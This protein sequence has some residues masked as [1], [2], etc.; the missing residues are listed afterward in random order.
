MTTME[1]LFVEIFDR[2]DR[3]IEQMQQQA[4][5][6]TQQLASRLVIDGIKP[7]SWLLSP[8]SNSHSSYLTELE[9]EKI[10][11]RLL[12]QP[13][14]ESTR[15]STGGRFYTAPDMSL[16]CQNNDIRSSLNH[17]AELDDSVEFPQNETNARTTS[18][19]NATDMSLECQNNDI[20]CSLNC[21]AEIDSVESPQSETNSRITSIYTAPVISLECQNNYTVCSLNRVAELDDRVESPQNAMNAKITSIYTAPDTSLAIIQRSRSRQKAREL[22]TNVKTTGKSRLSNENGDSN[23]KKDLLQATQ[24]KHP[25]EVDKCDDITGST[26]MILEEKGHKAND[27]T[28]H[29]VTLAKLSSSYEK[30][31]LENDLTKKGSSFDK[32]KLDGGIII[33]PTGDSLQQNGH[34]DNLPNFCLGSY[35]SKKSRTGKTHGTQSQ[36]KPYCGRITRS[37]SSSQQISRINKSVNMGTSVSCNLKEGGGALSHSVGDLMHKLTFSGKLLDAVETSQVLS[38][39]NGKTQTICSTG[40]VLNPDISSNMDMKNSSLNGNHQENAGIVVGNR[41]I[42]APV[43][44]QPVS[45]GKLD[46]SSSDCCMKVKPKQL[47][48]DEISQCDLNDIGSPLSKKRKPDGMLG[49]KCYPSNE[50]ASSIDRNSISN[51]FEQQLPKANV[52]SSSPN[53]AKIESS[54]NTNACTKDEMINIGLETNESPVVEDVKHISMVSLQGDIDVTCEVNVSSKE[55]GNTFNEETH[56]GNSHLKGDH[57]HKGE[58]SAAGVLMPVSPN[59]KASFISS[60]TKQ[61][62]GDFEVDLG[63]SKSNNIEIGTNLKLSRIKLNSAKCNTCPLNQQNTLEYQPNCF[64]DSRKFRV[65]IQRDA[66]HLNLKTPETDLNTVMESASILSSEKI[67][68]FQS[69]GIQSCDKSFHNEIVCDSPEGTE[70]LHELQAAEATVTEVDDG[71][72]TL[73]NTLKQSEPTTVLNM[74]KNSADVGPVSPII[75]DDAVVT[76]NNNFEINFPEWV[77]SYDSVQLSQN[78][79]KIMVSDEVTP[80]YESFL[81]DEEIGNINTENNDYGIDFDTLEIAST[82]YARASIIEQICKSTSMQTPLSQFKILDHMDIG[83]SVSLDEDSLKHLQTS[84]SCITENDYVFPQHHKVSYATPFSWQSKNYYSSPTGKLWERSASSSGSSEKQ[85]SSNP[86]LTCFP[87]EEDPSSNEENDE[88]EENIK[89]ENENSVKDYEMADEIQERPHEST[90]VWSQHA[91]HVSTKSIKYPDRYSSNSVSIEASVP[92]TREKVK[93][94]PKVHHGFKA[95]MHDKEN[96][97]SSIETRAS[98]RGNLSEMSRNKN[99]MRSGIPRQLQFA[100]KEA[101][102]NNIVSNITSFVPI[103]QQK[104]AAADCTGKRDIKVKALEAAEAAKRREQDKENERK[105]KKEAL[106]LERERMEKENAKERVLN[107]IKKKEELKKKEAD[108]AARKRLREEE[109][110]KQVA[111]KRKLDADAQKNQKIKLEKTRAGKVDIQKNAKNTATAGNTKKSE[112]LRRNRNADENSVRTHDTELRTDKTLAN[113]A[114]Q[115]DSVLENRDASNDFDEKEKATNIHEKSPINV[116]PGKL[117]SQEN[118][119]DISPYQCSD[120]ED[121]EEDDQRPIKKFVPSWAS[122]KRVAMVLPLQQKLNPESIF[123]ADSFCSMD[124]GNYTIFFLLLIDVLISHK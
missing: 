47:S 54:N 109:E 123:S 78:D 100:Q 85:L 77:S 2:K 30:T 25:S 110:R 118:S 101:K 68:L 51:F 87:I 66:I 24:D 114:Q 112:N 12:L 69:D 116:G 106:K 14:R 39:K 62:N 13:P 64:S 22:R 50:Y 80:V 122:K 43:V 115:V 21:V 111:K 108:I 34:G 49:Q 83:T 84:G 99:S 76:G 63:S 90:E 38:D 88:L 97:N 40:G 17:V 16:E 96:R 102:R 32:D 61:G 124:E 9:K 91:N 103:V 36:N 1:K 92:R 93:H 95:S 57:G 70:S 72:T 107:L 79:D 60:L 53:A 73:T 10:I 37:R 45:S 98:S 58:E 55:V 105:M 11:S 94:K 86:D 71:T 52:L 8:N 46:P 41:P 65:P 74:I 82:A 6:F 4:D 27:R 29:S 59:S 56:S 42:D 75:F 5:L 3:I 67:N 117:T 89:V 19:Y 18:I 120:D 31:R 20:G 81:I 7:P 15:N 113:V 28:S 44:M 119:Y 33:Q 23:S 35:A 26:S 48:F 121:D 104:Q